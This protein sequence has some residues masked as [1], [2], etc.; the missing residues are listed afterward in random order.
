MGMTF[1]CSKCEHPQRL[2]IP[3]RPLQ[4]FLSLLIAA[5]VGYLFVAAKVD[6][7]HA[8]LAQ[9]PSYCSYIQREPADLSEQ[10]RQMYNAGVPRL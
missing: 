10:M 9:K 5:T 2:A 6:C 4:F 1:G 8:S 3:M 7:A